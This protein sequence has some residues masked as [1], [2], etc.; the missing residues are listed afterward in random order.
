MKYSPASLLLISS[1][2]ITNHYTYILV[3]IELALGFLSPCGC[4]QCSDHELTGGR[5]GGLLT[6]YHS[7]P[8]ISVLHVVQTVYGAYPASYPVA[9]G[10]YS[11]AGKAAGA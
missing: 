1:F 3:N 5:P 8:K 7:I 11:F 6:W 9:T 2:Q 10:D 4:G